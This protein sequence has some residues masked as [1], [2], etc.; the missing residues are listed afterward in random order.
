MGKRARGNSYSKHTLIMESHRPIRA[1]IPRKH[2]RTDQWRQYRF[3]IT[4]APVFMQSMKSF[5][6]LWAPLINKGRMG[7]LKVLAPAGQRFAGSWA[8]NG[9]LVVVEQCS[10]LREC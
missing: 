5:E 1:V 4:L 6:A 3:L 7:W 2:E 8:G 9:P 10:I